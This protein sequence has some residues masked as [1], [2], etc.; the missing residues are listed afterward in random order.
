MISTTLKA[1]QE[2]NA[3]EFFL[4][5]RRDAAFHGAIERHSNEA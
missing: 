4:R 5:E 3:S 1:G 2:L